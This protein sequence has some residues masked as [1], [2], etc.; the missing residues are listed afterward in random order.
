[1]SLGSSQLTSRFLLF[2]VFGATLI[3]LVHLL[4]GI[5]MIVDQQLAGLVI[6]SV[7]VL[8]FCWAERL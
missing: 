7:I 3:A 1:M 2:N 4:G 8:V 5:E 6:S